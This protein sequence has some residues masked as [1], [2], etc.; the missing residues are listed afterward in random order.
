MKSNAVHLSIFWKLFT[1]FIG[2]SWATWAENLWASHV[3]AMQ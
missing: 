2:Q 1:V 3:Q